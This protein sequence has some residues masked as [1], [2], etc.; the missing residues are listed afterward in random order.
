MYCSGVYVDVCVCGGEG[1]AR[2]DPSSIILGSRQAGESARC[3][4]ADPIADPRR[5]LRTQEPQEP[6]EEPSLEPRGGKTPEV[7]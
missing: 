3:P 4:A 5:I 6:I 1:G 7:L 2:L